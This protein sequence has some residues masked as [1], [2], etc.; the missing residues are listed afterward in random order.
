MLLSI[1]SLWQY[2]SETGSDTDKAR[3]E[4]SEGRIWFL[5]SIIFSY[6]FL[7]NKLKIFYSLKI[8]GPEPILG[9]RAYFYKM[10][11]LWNIK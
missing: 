4:K 7:K 10:F 2:D 11:T 1:W 3:R 5:G 9:F 6:R 8:H